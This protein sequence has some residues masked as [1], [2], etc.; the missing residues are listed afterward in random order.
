MF[1]PGSSIL[2]L[3]LCFTAQVLAWRLCLRRSDRRWFKMATHSVF[4]LFNVAYFIAI[5]L[6]PRGGMTGDLWS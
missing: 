5:W 3:A 1:R 6:I 2:L 4:A